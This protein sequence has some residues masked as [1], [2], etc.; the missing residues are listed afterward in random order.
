MLGKTSE[1]FASQVQADCQW[2][3]GG[4]PGHPLP[5]GA[6]AGGWRGGGEW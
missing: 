1:Y 2:G 6:A 4:H 3:E 5:P